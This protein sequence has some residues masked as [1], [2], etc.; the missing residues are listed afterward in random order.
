MDDLAK[1]F[2]AYREAIPD[3]EPSRDFTPGV[4]RKIDARRSS[5]RLFRRF[6]EAFVTV[7]AVLTILISSVLIPYLRKAPVYSA[8]YVDVLA[9]E[10]SAEESAA[11]DAVRQFPPAEAPR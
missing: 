10:H 4:W 6:A 7:A 11:L 3:Q 2:A 9:A 8:T 5:V 1:L